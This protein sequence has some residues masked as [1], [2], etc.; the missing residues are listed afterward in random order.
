MR[1]L[2]L[3]VAVAF[4]AGCASNSYAE[5]YNNAPG[6]TPEM[7]A[8]GRSNPPPNEPAVARAS[9]FDGLADAYT[10]RG[11]GPIGASSFSS[12]NNERD[13][14]A[15]KQAKQVGADLVVIVDP[16]F[17]ESRTTSVAMTTPTTS[18]S[19]TNGSATAFGPL[20]SSTGFGSATTTTYGSQ[21]AYVPMTVNRYNYGAMYFVKRHYILGVVGRDLSDDERRRLQTNRGLVVNIVV[22]GTPA[23]L[24]DILPGDVLIAVNDLPI[25]GNTDFSNQMQQFR[26]QTVNLTAIRGAD[27]ITKKVSLGE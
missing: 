2:A 3:A 26:G 25:V 6:V 1:I 12:G 16:K 27:K 8:S 22:D 4:V 7:I 15:V 5:F 11:Y 10:R 20:G 18:T 24:N 9:T 13:E 14:S 23:Y 17:S 21:T 19:F